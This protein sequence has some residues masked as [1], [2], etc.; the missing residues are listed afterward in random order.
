MELRQLRIFLALAEELHFGRTAER[1]QIS[2]P[3]VSEATRSLES[4]LGTSLFERTSRVRLTPAGEW[5]I[6]GRNLGR[7]SPLPGV[8][9]N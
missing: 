8:S 1:L 3:G 6:L 4:R 9:G 2:Q 5:C 7:K